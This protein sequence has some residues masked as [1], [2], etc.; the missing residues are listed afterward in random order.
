M[1][2]PCPFCGNAQP[3]ISEDDNGFARWVFCPECEAD[4][5]PIDYRW[6]GTKDEARNIVVG[7]W[8][9]RTPEKET[10][11]GGGE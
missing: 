3:E 4:G 1:L 6:H 8:N 2:K 10:N 9:N 5:P 11:A 7:Q